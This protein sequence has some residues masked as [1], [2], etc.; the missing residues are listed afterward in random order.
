[1]QDVTWTIA[2]GFAQRKHTVT[3]LTTRLPDG[4]ERFEREGV[5]VRCLVRSRP[6]RYSTAFLREV[7]ATFGAL[8]RQERFALVH[9]QSYAGA[10]LPPDVNGRLVV[11]L[12]GVWFSETELEPTVFRTLG[13]RDKVARLLRWPMIFAEMRRMHRFAR[14]GAIIVVDSEF[15]LRE[16]RRVN[17]ALGTRDVRVVYPGIDSDRL[18]PIARAEA[19]R[20]L[21]LHGAVL[22]C[23]G[24]LTAAKGALVAVRA[25]ERLRTPGVR[26][27]I[28][29]EGAYK[30]AVVAYVREHRLAGVSF[31]D[32]PEAKKSLYL[33]AADLFVY[34]ELTR[35]AFGLVAAEA[36]A[37]G[38]PVVASRAGA[39]PE[40]VGDCGTLVA[41][42]DTDALAAAIDAALAAPARLADLGARGR[43]R[44]VE[45]FGRERM[46]DELEAIYAEVTRTA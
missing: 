6:E 9:S 38:T 22:L 13:A 4:P 42:G 33:S 30:P 23:L 29:G 10:G 18:V 12:H 35:P 14:R 34:P 46:L 32:V 17:H 21:G 7:A 37:C 36:L 2:T 1:M 39:I 26:L 41:P 40:V 11:Q 16:L 20:R 43:A 25:F 19:K 3:L 31:V 5:D 27:L 44:V 24:R 45:R 28:A 15:S 8:D